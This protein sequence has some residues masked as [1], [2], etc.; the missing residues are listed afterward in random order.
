MKQ[1]NSA[2]IRKVTAAGIAGV[3]VTI[4][5]WLLSA[6]APELEIPEEV[7]AALTTVIAFIVAYFVPPAESD[8]IEEA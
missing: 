3:L 2:P 1:A 7:A 5:L 4:I 8:G 6:F